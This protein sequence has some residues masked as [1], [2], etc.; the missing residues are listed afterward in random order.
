MEDE[1]VA[2]VLQPGHAEAAVL[3]EKAVSRS[4]W[5]IFY[6]LIAAYYVSGEP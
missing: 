5:G 6:T 3:R 4:V 2:G 1:Q